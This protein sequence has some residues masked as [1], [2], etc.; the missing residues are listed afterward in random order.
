[1]AANIGII[2]Q[3]DYTG[4]GGG[5]TVTISNITQDTGSDRYLYFIIQHVNNVVPTSV[6]YN[7]VAMTKFRSFSG[8]SV[9]WE[10]YELANPATGNNNI[11]ITYPAFQ[12]YGTDIG[13]MAIST[14]DADGY[15]GIGDDTGSAANPDGLDF[16][17]ALQGTGSAIIATTIVPS[18]TQNGQVIEIDGSTKSS[19][20]PYFQQVGTANTGA[21]WFKENVSTGN[22]NVK[23]T[24]GFNMAALAFEVKAS[25]VTPP[26]TRRIIIM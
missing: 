13:Y 16:N 5:T 4:P 7:G 21:G 23:S 9:F 26:T 2:T 17:L 8:Q 25:A 10:V 12:E 20:F 15:G 14:T 24:V 19:A 1:M 18:P 3:G 22:C 6:T 11:V